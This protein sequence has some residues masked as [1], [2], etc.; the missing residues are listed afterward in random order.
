MQPLSAADP[1][2]M[3]ECQDCLTCRLRRVTHLAQLL[4]VPIAFQPTRL[5][6]ETS[7]LC[8]TRQYPLALN[9]KFRL[10]WQQ[11]VVHTIRSGGWAPTQLLHCSDQASN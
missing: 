3:E 11:A 5:A 4:F 7:Y 6:I 2:R 10:F 9:H 8:M 1:W